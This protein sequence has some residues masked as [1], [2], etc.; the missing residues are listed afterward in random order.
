MKKML[1][2]ASAALALL[3]SCSTE[4]KPEDKSS[5]GLSPVICNVEA[6]G[7]TV[8]LKITGKEAWTVELTGPQ[9]TRT[10]ARPRLLK[11]KANLPLNLL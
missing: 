1:F 11:E 7:G 5:F 2:F 9:K 8:E 4:D 10:G 3:A 6:A